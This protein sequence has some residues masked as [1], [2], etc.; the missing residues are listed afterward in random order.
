MPPPQ[1]PPL[2]EEAE[3][4]PDVMVI[5]LTRVSPNPEAAQSEMHSM[6]LTWPVQS[7]VLLPRASLS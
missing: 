5:S 6:T 7:P 1:D 3:V 4:C 2:F